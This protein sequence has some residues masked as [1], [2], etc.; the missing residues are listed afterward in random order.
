M[1]GDGALEITVVGE[2]P[3]MAY[4]R[5]HLTEY[6]EHRDP[7]KLSMCDKKWFQDHKARMKK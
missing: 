3:R 5:V 6:F 7:S 4:D 1:V 2:E